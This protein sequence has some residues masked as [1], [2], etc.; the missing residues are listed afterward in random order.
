MSSNNISH[1]D[2][3]KTHKFIKESMAHLATAILKVDTK[4]AIHKSIKSIDLKE[5][6]QECKDLVERL[7][8]SI[9]EEKYGKE[10]L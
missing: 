8:A 5:D 1:N 7:S 3:I 2:L 10:E 6:L 9:D 4:L